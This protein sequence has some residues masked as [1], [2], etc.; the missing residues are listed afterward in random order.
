MLDTKASLASGPS[1][2]KAGRDLFSALDAVLHPGKFLETLTPLLSREE[3]SVRKAALNLLT[4]RLQNNENALRDLTISVKKQQRE[5]NESIKIAGLKLIDEL[6]SLAIRDGTPNAR[7][8]A[9]VALEAAGMRFGRDEDATHYANALVNAA[10]QVAEKC[11]FARDAG[12]ANALKAIN[13]STSNVLGSAAMCLAQIARATGPKFIGA[14]ALAAPAMTRNAKLATQICSKSAAARNGETPENVLVVL[15]ATISAIDAFCEDHLAKFMSPYLLDIL[16]VATHP[17]LCAKTGDGNEGAEQS[18]STAN[19]TKKKSRD[20]VKTNLTSLIAAKYAAAALRSER[21]A[22][23]FECRI[24]MPPLEECWVTFIRE[25]ESART[26]NEA[27]RSRLAFLEVSNKI[28]DRKDAT[29]AHRSVLFSI[30]LEAM[31]VRRQFAEEDDASTLEVEQV[32]TLAVHAVANL[33][34]KC[35]EKEFTPFYAKC[36]EW[37]KARAAE[38]DTARWRLSALFRLTS[39]LADQLR[40]V[41]VPFYRH[42]LDLT[43]ACLDDEALDMIDSSKRKKKKKG[44]EEKSNTNKNDVMDEWRMK[45]FALA[46]LRRCF[47]YDSVNFLTQERFN[48]F[49]PLVAKHL[50]KDPPK[51]SREY[52]MNT[53]EK[54]LDNGEDEMEEISGNESIGV[55]LNLGAECVGCCAALFAAAPDEA[56]WKTLHRNILNVSRNYEHSRAKLLVIATL[57]KIVENTQ[58]EYLVLLPEAIPFLSELLEDDDLEVEIATQDLLDKLTKLSGEDLASLLEHGYGELKDRNTGVVQPESYV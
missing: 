1:A 7:Q 47:A 25:S 8:A 54:L 6:A 32:E 43:A 46:A 57:E 17:V 29:P 48:Q 44:D 39:A 3:S 24:L 41:F 49:A 2:S 12:E 26:A 23:A 53:L 37:A 56:L 13:S 11:C 5:S 22:T 9:L 27:L 40:A 20:S 4:D 15:T 30:A 42:V 51:E 38:K 19:K 52:E 31:D 55:K 10:K 50:A 21:L 36:V 33:A 34:V 58:E 14:L 45:A 18:E 28:A 35:T 16:T